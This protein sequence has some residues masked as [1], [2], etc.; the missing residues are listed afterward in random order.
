MYKGEIIKIS[1]NNTYSIKVPSLGFNIKESWA[2]VGKGN[3]PKYE[4]GDLVVVSKLNDETW[5]I[6]GYVYG[7]VKESI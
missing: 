7:Q 3:Y 4:V 2:L 6:L 1:E 5:V